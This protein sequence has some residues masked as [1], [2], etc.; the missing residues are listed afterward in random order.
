MFTFHL[1]AAAAGNDTPGALAA[2]AEAGDAGLPAVHDLIGAVRAAGMLCG[3]TIKPGTPVELT[4]PYLPSLD[5]VLIM[6]VEPGF[7]GQSF[8]PETM[9]KVR[10]PPWAARRRLPRSRTPTAQP[11]PPALHRRP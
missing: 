6:S 11:P 4:V 3:L 9:A 7:G 2:A 10:G 1:E 8:M 5:M